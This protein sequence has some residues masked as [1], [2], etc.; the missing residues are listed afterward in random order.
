LAG[1][2]PQPAQAGG[3]IGGLSHT[4]TTTINFIKISKKISK[5]FFINLFAI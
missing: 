4:P 2:Y 5:K 1:I 3:G